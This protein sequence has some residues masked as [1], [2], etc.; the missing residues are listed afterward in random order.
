MFA[1]LFATN[2]IQHDV[3]RRASVFGSCS[4]SQEVLQTYRLATSSLY[5]FFEQNLCFNPTSEQ[6]EELFRLHVGALGQPAAAAATQLAGIYVGIFKV[7]C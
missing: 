6:S 5:A 4:S 2:C 1:T 3:T 7:E